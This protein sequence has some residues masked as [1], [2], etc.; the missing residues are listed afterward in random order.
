MTS[1][2]PAPA[3]APSRLPGVVACL[4]AGLASM[5]LARL[6]GTAVPAVSPLLVAILLGIV[7]GNL[8]ALPASWAPGLTQGSKTMLRAGIVL[9]GLQVSLATIVGLGW[10]V[11]LA[12]VVVV[13]AGFAT[14]VVAGRLLGV[15]PGLALL[16][17]SGFSICGAAAVAA[18]DGVLESDEQD[19]AV[20]LALVVLFGTLMIPVVPL[21]ASAMGVDPHTTGLWAGLSVHEVAQVVAVGGIVGSCALAVAVVAKLAR[22]VLLAPVMVGLAVWRRRQLRAEQARAGQA[23]G[24]AAHPT[25]GQDA[26]T[27]PPLVPL[28]VV[29]FLAMVLVRTWVPLPSVLLEV[30]TVAQ[31][32]LL[33]A[34]M[35][36][37]GT[38]VQ[39]SKLRAVGGAPF[40][41]AGI[42]TAVVAA[43]GLGGAVLA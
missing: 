14:A 40:A 25:A 3:P 22:V 32:V 42:T 23:D 26:V 19:V 31:T 21:A 43:V 11:V 30:A 10:R 17:G 36:A 39:W 38:G 34:A 13:V 24:A 4:V 8:V 20:A 6:I 29:A 1:P 28:F 12:V 7:V 9:L 2:A 37:L 27:L 41:L 18:A 35:W 33:A 5:G 16:V 15:R